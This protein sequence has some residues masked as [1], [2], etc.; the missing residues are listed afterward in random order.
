MTADQAT[1]DIIHLVYEA[2]V[3]SPDPFVQETHV[4]TSIRDVLEEFSLGV[5]ADVDPYDARQEARGLQDDL[6]DSE[7][8]NE[9]LK[10]K[11]RDAEGEVLSLELELGE[12]REKLRYTQNLLGEYVGK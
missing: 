4:E 6:E 10:T 2:A 3:I 11:L 12:L 5:E 8:E 7:A 9:D 1:A